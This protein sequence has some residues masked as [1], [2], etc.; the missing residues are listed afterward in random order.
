MNHLWKEILLSDPVF[1]NCK[2][3]INDSHCESDKKYIKYQ[4]TNELF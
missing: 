3:W 1:K 2:F 4:L